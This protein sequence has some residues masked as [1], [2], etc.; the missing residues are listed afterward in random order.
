MFVLC[1]WMRG[2]TRRPRAR[3]SFV[4]PH[5]TQTTTRSPCARMALIKWLKYRGTIS[6]TFVQH[7]FLDNPMARWSWAQ[8][9][10][11]RCRHWSTTTDNTRCTSRRNC[12]M[13]WNGRARFGYI[14][15]ASD[16]HLQ[17]TDAN[18]LRRTAM[19]LCRAEA[20]YLW[21]TRVHDAF[22][23]LYMQV[24]YTGRRVASTSRS[25]SY[26][27]IPLLHYTP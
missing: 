11:T 19:M 15:M 13:L 3:S 22:Y 8:N 17:T 24:I 9:S 26:H 7:T 18:V 6:V 10:S 2:C 16:T 23:E 4:C 12:R 1:R 20:D 27:K 25:G 21:H 5:R 14:Q